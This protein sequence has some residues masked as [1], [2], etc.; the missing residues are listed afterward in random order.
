MKVKKPELASTHITS[1]N[2]AIPAEEAVIRQ[3]AQEV[4]DMLPPALVRKH[5]GGFEIHVF[6]DATDNRAGVW[7]QD[8]K[9]LFL[10]QAHGGVSQNFIYHEMGHW[11]HDN[12]PTS[13]R[14]AVKSHYK[15]R[16]EGEALQHDAANGF[17]YRRD[18]LYDNYTGC[19]YG[20]KRANEGTEIVSRH[21]EHLHDGDNYGFGVTSDEHLSTLMKGQAY[22]ETASVALSIFYYGRKRK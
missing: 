12:A 22:R 20:G 6:H 4:F 3:H 7:D 10:N 11:I 19:D 14:A 1:I 9:R 21:L 17:S 13:F 8:N 5:L 2:S 18:Q 15:Q 16:T